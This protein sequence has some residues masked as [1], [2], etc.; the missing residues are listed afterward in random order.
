M[1]ETT[2]NINTDWIIWWYKEIII[3]I[4]KQ[5]N[6]LVIMLKTNLIFWDV[7]WTIYRCSDNDLKF[8]TK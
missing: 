8:G 5:V 6:K 4:F 3:N 7:H 2:G 1:C